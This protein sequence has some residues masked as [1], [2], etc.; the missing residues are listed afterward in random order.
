MVKTKSSTS[1]AP[2]RNKFEER[3]AEQLG[4]GFEYETIKLSFIVPARKATY[5]PDFID[6]QNKRLIEAKGYLRASDRKKMVL[7][8][9]Q[10]PDWTIHFI[11]QKAQQTISKTSKTTYAAWAEN[12]GFTW[13]ELPAKR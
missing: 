2:Y 4:D 7:I 9:E 3:V 12:H 6:H 13:E 5:T 8:K 11:F 1:T 10:N